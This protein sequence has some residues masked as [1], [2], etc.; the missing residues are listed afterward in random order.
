MLYC[1]S[2][3]RAY[4]PDNRIPESVNILKRLTSPGRAKSFRDANP[5]VFVHDFYKVVP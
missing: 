3:C 5:E 4:L 2:V 1:S